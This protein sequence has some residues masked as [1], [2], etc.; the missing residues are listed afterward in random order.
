MIF[1]L[2]IHMMGLPGGSDGKESACHVGDLGSIPGLGRSPGEGD[3]LP[4]PAFWPGEFH[5]I[6]SMRL[7]R[8][9]HDWATFTFA[10]RSQY[11]CLGNPM[12]RGALW[13]TVHGVAKGRTRLSNQTTTK[14]TSA[15]YSVWPH[16]WG[17]E[18]RGSVDVECTNIYGTERVS[19]PLKSTQW[20]RAGA[21]IW[22]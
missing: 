17:C 16:R 13:A 22:T 21:G 11:S 14:R 20:G 5:G 1:D 9:G 6:Q 3:W 19:D 18:W 15:P 4:T 2:T 8:V 12:D 10:S 7:Q